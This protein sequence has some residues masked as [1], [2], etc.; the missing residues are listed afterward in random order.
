MDIN[1]TQGLTIQFY[2]SFYQNLES[3][4]NKHNYVINHIWNY[5]ET[6]IQARRQQR[7]KVLAK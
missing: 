3:L 5:D 2:Q 4:Y 7:A 1:Q 6:C